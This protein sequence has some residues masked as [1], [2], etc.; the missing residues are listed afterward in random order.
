MLFRSGEEDVYWVGRDAG[1]MIRGGSNYSCQQ[2]ADE[3]RDIVRRQFQLRDSEFDLAVIGLKL[4]SEHE[5]SCCVM[6][7]VQTERIDAVERLREA[8]L[9]TSRELASKGARPDRVVFGKLP[10][11][12]KG[13]IDVRALRAGFRSSESVKVD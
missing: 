6:L 3:L 8:F 1:L 9:A 11:N 2:V 4:S 13:A 10:R 7:E 12:F 5:D